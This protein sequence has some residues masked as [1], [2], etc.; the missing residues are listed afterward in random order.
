[1]DFSMNQLCRNSFHST[2]QRACDFLPGRLLKIVHVRKNN[3][4]NDKCKKDY[5]EWER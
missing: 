1:M 2:P 5:N 3:G 4:N